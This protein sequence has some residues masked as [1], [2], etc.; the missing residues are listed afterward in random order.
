MG[1]WSALAV[2]GRNNTCGDSF[3]VLVIM[4]AG[5]RWNPDTVTIRI[6]H[7]TERVFAAREFSS[8]I[9]V[10]VFLSNS[11]VPFSFPGQ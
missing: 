8:G 9:A 5:G 6:F 3:L 7:E 2:S 4:H 10:Q 1:E 11:P